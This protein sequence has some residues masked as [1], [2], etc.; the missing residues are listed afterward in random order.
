[1]A[2]KE[3]SSSSRSGTLHLR[4]VRA[5]ISALIWDL[6]SFD[7]TTIQHPAD[8]K[9]KALAARINRTLADIFG[10]HSKEYKDHS[11][12][13]LNTL[14]PLPG[15]ESPLPEVRLGYQR[16][17]NSAAQK[18]NL[19]L[20]ILDK[21][22]GAAKGADTPARQ[23]GA[24]ATSPDE[25][26]VSLVTMRAKLRSRSASSTF[27]NAAP[28]VGTR[29]DHKPRFGLAHG[30][31]IE[32]QPDKPLHSLE[33]SRKK[34]GERKID[35]RLYRTDGPGKKQKHRPPVALLD[36]NLVLEYL[37]AMLSVREAEGPGEEESVQRA[38]ETAFTRP[39]EQSPI[40]TAAAVIVVDHLAAPATPMGVE[41]KED[42]RPAEPE[43]Y[44]SSEFSHLE[45]SGG[46]LPDRPLRDEPGEEALLPV[47]RAIVP[48]DDECPATNIVSAMTEETLP[49]AAPQEGLGI[50]GRDE[51]A[52]GIRLEIYQRGVY[53]DTPL[54]VGS[55]VL[56]LP[57]TPEM[58]LPEPG[59]EERQER[60]PWSPGAEVTMEMSIQPVTEPSPAHTFL[61]PLN[62]PAVTITAREEHNLQVAP[63]S[64]HLHEE[65]IGETETDLP[66]LS[67]Q[68]VSDAAPSE[69][70]Q[71]EPSRFEHGPFSLAAAEY[72]AEPLWHETA[73]LELSSV[74]QRAGEPERSNGG[75]SFDAV[76]DDLPAP[77]LEQVE[78]PIS[79][80]SLDLRDIETLADRFAKEL[81]APPEPELR[82]APEE[83][84]TGDSLQIS[85]GL[86]QGREETSLGSPEGPTD[87][88]RVPTAKP[89]EPEQN[90]FA[91]KDYEKKESRPKTTGAVDLR[92][93]IRAI[94]ERINDLK[95]FDVATITERFDPRAR[96]LRDSVNRTIADVF[97]RNTR[98][99]WHH[100]L[101][102][103]DA[104]PIALGSPKP[105]SADVRDSYL[106]GID[107]AVVKLTAIM[108]SLG[109]KLDQS[110]AG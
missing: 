17:I 13:S 32:V 70:V 78:E 109:E 94:M 48:G 28:G 90:I 86:D 25:E 56:M 92:A 97:G 23:V 49:F 75:I 108:E 98:A 101:P 24:K 14:P 50:T 53:V 36:E 43:G 21:K 88:V 71:E 83:H 10:R 33:K 106:R 40:D 22:L 3:H 42:S 85:A 61:Y 95:N 69:F 30:R 37:E 80:S 4:R 107:K 55:E 11:I 52:E 20:D 34:Q 59:A 18:L 1:M 39:D 58:L 47:D 51:P 35:G 41:E 29:V 62:P 2:Q 99:Y 7:V 46:S 9:G 15:S 91:L 102:S 72:G 16:G 81:K 110:A 73:A 103:F 93:Q 5:K 74:E 57:D 45:A 65:R 96:E 60:T 104:S 89:S 26:K 54:G 19:L 105:S 82:A 66:G 8:P 84:P 12:R 38:P 87:A 77:Y 79:T 63:F 27:I 68:A 6:R 67:E 76:E 64:P 31:A 44:V 100:S